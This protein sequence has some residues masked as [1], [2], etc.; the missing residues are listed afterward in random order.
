M[1]QNNMIKDL[2]HLV[3]TSLEFD[4]ESFDEILKYKKS[5]DTTFMFKVFNDSSS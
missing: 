5:F 1:S 4:Y 3:N 2:I